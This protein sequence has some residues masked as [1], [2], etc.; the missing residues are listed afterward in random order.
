MDV[1]R[2]TF[3]GT[4]PRRARDPGRVATGQPSSHTTRFP[5]PGSPPVAGFFLSGEVK[6]LDVG[7]SSF[8]AIAAT[9]HEGV[10]GAAAD[11]YRNR[12]GTIE[13]TSESSSA[14]RCVTA[15][16][17]VCTA[18][19]GSTRWKRRWTMSTR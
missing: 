6:W 1:W 15:A 9:T 18:D 4:D 7:T 3:P 5:A 12:L 8:S 16:V 11:Y 10:C 14:P 19:T 17:A 2:R 13:T